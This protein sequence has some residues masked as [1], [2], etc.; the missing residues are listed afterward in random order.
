[1]LFF[2]RCVFALAIN[3]CPNR[4]CAVKTHPFLSIWLENSTTA[5]TRFSSS[6]PPTLYTPSGFSLWDFSAHAY[7]LLQRATPS[8]FIISHLLIV[9]AN[10]MQ[11]LPAALTPVTRGWCFR[12]I[13]PACY[14]F[15]AP[16]SLIFRGLSGII[17]WKSTAQQDGLL[18]FLYIS[19]HV[20]DWVHCCCKHLLSYQSMWIY[21]L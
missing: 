7:F 1:M 14:S 12:Q 16:L 5:E 21:K 2:N 6:S 11:Q 13:L 4:V 10:L 8:S 20:L 17:S 15:L 18:F 19:K 3:L 9:L